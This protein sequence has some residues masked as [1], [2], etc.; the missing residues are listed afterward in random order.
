MRVEYETQKWLSL[1]GAVFRAR[2]YIV[3]TTTQYMEVRRRAAF[4][5][6]KDCLKNSRSRWV[7]IM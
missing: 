1:H 2:L 4:M 5:P 3:I 6:V 7:N